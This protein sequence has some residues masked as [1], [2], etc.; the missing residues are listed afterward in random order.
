[1]SNL[2][3]IDKTLLDERAVFHKQQIYSDINRIDQEYSLKG[4]EIKSPMIN[5][6]SMLH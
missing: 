6:I 4:K 1:M 2:D 3:G 5:F